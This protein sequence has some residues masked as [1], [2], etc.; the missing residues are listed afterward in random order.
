MTQKLQLDRRH[1]IKM[2]AVTAG[3]FTIVPRHVLGGQGYIAP[4]EKLNHG[5]IGVGS[6][7]LN[8]INYVKDDPQGELVAVCDVDSKHLKLGLKRGLAITDGGCKGYHDFREVL[9]R[10]DVDIVHVVTP[11]HWHG[12]ISRLSMP[13]SR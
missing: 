9:A 4:S 13:P 5:I 3:A 7:G 8:H 1:F 10:P 6:M 2:T 12:L 11:P